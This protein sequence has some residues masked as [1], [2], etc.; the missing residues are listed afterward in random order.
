MLYIG[1]DIVIMTLYG[2]V[3]TFAAAVA[4]KLFELD[5]NIPTWVAV[6]HTA[7]A[8]VVGYAIMAMVLDMIVSR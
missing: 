3:L 2:M 4:R 1:I 8:M 7:L 5:E 6:F